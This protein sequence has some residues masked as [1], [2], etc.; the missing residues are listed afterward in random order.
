MK[1]V[2]KHH[3]LIIEGSA[4]VAVASLRKEKDRYKGKK[5]AIIIC[6][7]NVSEAVLKRLICE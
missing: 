7:G 5:V 3:H 2:M 1:L 4:G 6:G